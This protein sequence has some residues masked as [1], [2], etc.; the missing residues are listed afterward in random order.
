MTSHA[1]QRSNKT[2]SKKIREQKAVTER[3]DTAIPTNK[4]SIPTKSIYNQRRRGFQNMREEN[5]E[6]LME[7]NRQRQR[8]REKKKE[9]EE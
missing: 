4:T 5:T 6:K 3:Q 7:M 1:L 2:E 8:E 9:E